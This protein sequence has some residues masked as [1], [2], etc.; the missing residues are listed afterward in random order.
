MVSE[1]W[2]SI[3]VKTTINASSDHG[4]LFNMLGPWTAIAVFYLFHPPVAYRENG[5]VLVWITIYSISIS[6][7]FSFLMTMW[8]VERAVDFKIIKRNGWLY[9]C[10]L[11]HYM[12]E[13]TKHL[14]DFQR[15]STVV[16][17]YKPFTLLI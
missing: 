13:S 7:L 5:D 12:E 3:F 14:R 6:I 17:V 9:Q 15:T 1:K 16:P 11:Q 2:K 4:E 10:T 8:I